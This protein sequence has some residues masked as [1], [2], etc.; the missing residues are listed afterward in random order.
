MD[1]QKVGKI[2]HYFDKIQVGVLEVSEGVVKVGDRIR[3]GEEDDGFEQVVE[4]MQVDHQPVEVLKAGQEA[5][6][7]LAAA[8]HEGA[9]VY[10]ISG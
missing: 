10:K 5:G 8:S 3:V 1:Y 6:L 7:K 2:I 9:L 4:S